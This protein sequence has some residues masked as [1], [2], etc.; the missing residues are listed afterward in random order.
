MGKS[1]VLITL[2]QDTEIS[3]HFFGNIQ[4]TVYITSWVLVC[5]NFYLGEVRP[6]TGLEFDFLK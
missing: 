6:V 1:S 3:I 2:L 4:Q 5:G